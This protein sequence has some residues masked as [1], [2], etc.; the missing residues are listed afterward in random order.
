MPIGNEDDPHSALGVLRGLGEQPQVL[1]A[2]ADGEV[3]GCVLGAA[4]DGPRIEAYGLAP[5]G[6]QPGDG[7]LAFVGVA[8]GA[9]G[10]RARLIADRRLELYGTKGRRGPPGCRSLA[11]LLF[12]RWLAAPAVRAFPRLF[13]R[14]RRQ[15]KPILHLSAAHGFRRCG[16][17]E[18][19]FRGVR[20]ERIILMRSQQ[21]AA[22]APRAE[23]VSA[24]TAQALRD[25]S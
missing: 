20:Q 22:A 10:A 16:T 6:A 8:P 2:C 23:R 5:F 19:D 18:I 25:A 7:L 21:A 13:I 11:G 17:I 3:L 14:T 12:A 15:I 9:Q 1:I 24:Q 4:L